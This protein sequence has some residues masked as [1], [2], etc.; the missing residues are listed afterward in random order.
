MTEV[1]GISILAEEA[2]FVLAKTD[3]VPGHANFQLLSS[4][5]WLASATPTF[6][7]G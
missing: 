7:K 5:S 6:G 2:L 1:T 4:A 3:M